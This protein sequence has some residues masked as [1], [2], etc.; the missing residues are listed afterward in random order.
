MNR[1]QS[2]Q[3]WYLKFSLKI[4]LM[5]NEFLMLDDIVDRPQ[6]VGYSVKFRCL[7]HEFF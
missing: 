1:N 3:H 5:G 4:E 6:N 2:H 7:I